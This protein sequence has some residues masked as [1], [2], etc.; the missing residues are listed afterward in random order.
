MGLQVTNKYY[1]HI[2]ARVVNVNVNSTTTMWEAPVITDQ[3]IFAN[4]P[5]TA[6]HDIKEKTCRLIDMAVP[7]ERNRKTTQVPRPADWGQQDVES[8]DKN[9]VSYKWSIRNS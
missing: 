3:T 8:E 4:W 7:N 9:C 6:L 2:T 1:E 5:D